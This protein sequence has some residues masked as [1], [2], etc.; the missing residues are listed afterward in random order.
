[1]YI[2]S[3]FHSSLGS[4]KWLGTKVSQ[5]CQSIVHISCYDVSVPNHCWYCSSSVCYTIC[6]PL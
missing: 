1:M 5:T 2:G 6:G 3:V 4:C